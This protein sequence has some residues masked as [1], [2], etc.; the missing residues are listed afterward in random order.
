MSVPLRWQEP[1]IIQ[2]PLFAP[3]PPLRRRAP[4]RVARMR[5]AFGLGVACLTMSACTALGFQIGKANAA[6]TPTLRMVSM[7]AA[8]GQVALTNGTLERKLGFVTVTGSVFS[9]AKHN[10]SQVEAVVELLDSQ[11]RTLQM[12]S[13][14]VAYDPLPV[15]QSAP[16]RVEMSDNPRAAGWRVHFRQMFGASLD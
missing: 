7:P 15:G 16:F 12:Q 8:N 13:A 5:V 4:R 11:N 14:L 2:E 10:L 1:E 9:R 3:Q 6:S